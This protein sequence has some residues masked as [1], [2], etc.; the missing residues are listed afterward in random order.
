MFIRYFYI[1]IIREN[2][3]NSLEFGAKS[4][5]SNGFVYETDRLFACSTRDVN[6]PA[7]LIL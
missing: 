1:Q 6:G 4:L 5:N 3:T 7:I 2:V